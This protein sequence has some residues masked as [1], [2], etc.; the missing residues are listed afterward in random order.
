VGLVAAS[1][2]A[3]PLAGLPYA[4]IAIVLGGG[5]LILALRGLR[6]D[7]GAPLARRTML[8]SL[9][10]LCVLFAVLVADAR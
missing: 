5:F 8:Y 2:A 6:Q 1:A 7:A 10:Y 4:G 3:A 9:V